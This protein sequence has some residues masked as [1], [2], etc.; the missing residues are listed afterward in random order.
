[1][2]SSEQ[3]AKISD[4]LVKAQA[5]FES[6]KKDKTAKAGAYSYDY[7]DLANVIDTVKPVLTEFSL[8]VVQEAVNADG[9]VGVLTRIIHDS[10][11]WFEFGP[12]ILPAG[13]GPQGHGG[14][15]TYARRYALAAAL[16]IATEEDDD[17]AAAQ[18]V[19]PTQTQPRAAQK[20]KPQPDPVAAAKVSEP[21]MKAIHA[22]GTK[23]GLDHEA[24]R[25]WAGAN[26][27]IESLTELTKETAGQLIEH[28]GTLA[29]APKEAK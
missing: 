15:V 8:A 5:K 27:G 16:G 20:A 1:M 2:R 14:S 26:L 28:L 23:K 9:G 25:D 13:G 7:A 12:L 10:G 18:S 22:L 29:D 4:A 6:P 24:L 19:A 3:I 21:Q 11:E 17:A